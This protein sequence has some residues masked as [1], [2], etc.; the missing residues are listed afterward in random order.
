MNA[1]DEII[2]DLGG[3]ATAAE[4]RERGH[5]AWEL[6]MLL[7]YGRLVRVRKGWY[8]TTST[9]IELVRA[10]R[11]GGRLACVSAPGGHELRG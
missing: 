7:D 9:P 6:R 10:W 3:V 5:P 4:L 8:A 2:R 1:V 11:V